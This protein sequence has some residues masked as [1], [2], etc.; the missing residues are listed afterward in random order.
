MKFAEKINGYRKEFI[1]EQYQRIVDNCKDYEKITRK[2]MLA[3]IYNVYADYNNIIDICTAR[4]LKFLK[5][6]VDNINRKNNNEIQNKLLNEKYSW[7]IRNLSNKFLINN[8]YNNI[9]SIPDEVLLNVKEAIEKVDFKQKEKEDYLNALLI[10]YCKIQGSALLDVVISF[11]SD[12]T[13]IDKDIMYNHIFDS[14]FFNYYVY[15]ISKKYE[16][17]SKEVPVAVYHEYYFLLD[18]IE[19]RR[20]KQGIAGELLVDVE[21][22]MNIFYYDFD[23]KNDKI[24]KFLQE[25]KK[26]P[27]MECLFKD[28]IRECAMLNLDRKALKESMKNSIFYPNFDFTEFFKI[29]DEA[30]DEMPSAVL[31]GFTPNQARKVKLEQMRVDSKKKKNYQKQQNACLSKNDAKLFYKI[32]FALLEFTNNKYKIMPNLKIYNKTGINPNFLEGIIE[33]FWENKNIIVFEFCLSNPYKF[34]KNELQITSEFKKGFRDLF[35]IVAYEKEYTAILNKEK[36]YMIKGLNDNIDNIISY[37]NLPYMVTTSVI[38]FKDVLV[39]DGIFM[40]MQVKLGVDFEKLVEEKYNCSD[41]H[42]HI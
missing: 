14:K 5:I 34:N 28:Y 2:Q 15:I 30:M 33:K 40:A 10:G 12:I 4:E 6:V 3:E 16:G 31:N 35:A 9:P 18:E 41:K 20:K 27:L 11:G 7:E 23:I 22:Y 29:M 26:I 25:Q 38:P 17:I 8:L 21:S 24:N 37:K 32:Y 1:Y 13:K 19:Q 42:Y 39:Y 36:V